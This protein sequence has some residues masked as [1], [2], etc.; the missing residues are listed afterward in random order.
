MTVN[1]YFTNKEKNYDFFLQFQA[2]MNSRA[3]GHGSAGCEN[4]ISAGK[5]VLQHR[6]CEDRIS[7]H[8]VKRFSQ[9]I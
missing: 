3:V 6:V 7:G 8:C 5:G 2:E 9:T 4:T 1:S